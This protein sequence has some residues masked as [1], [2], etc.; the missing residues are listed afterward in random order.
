MSEATISAEIREQIAAIAAFDDGSVVIDSWD[1]MDGPIQNEPFCRIETGSL[2]RYAYETICP[3]YTWQIPVV[4]I[5]PFADWDQTVSAL[6]VLRQS[7]VSKF[8]TLAYQTVLGSGVDITEIRD[9]NTTAPVGVVVDPYIGAD[10]VGDTVPTYLA[11]P[12]LFT[13]EERS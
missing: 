1:F 4:I 13:V 8:S 2:V 3:T 7:I 5:K 12:L 11:L 6:G 10:E 9:Q